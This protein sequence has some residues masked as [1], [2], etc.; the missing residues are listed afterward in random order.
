M[1]VCLGLVLGLLLDSL[2]VYVADLLLWYVLLFVA[3]V[4]VVSTVF[5]GFDLCVMFLIFRFCLGVIYGFCIGFVICVLV[6]F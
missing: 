2:V 1:F 3:G 4:W 5:F 6:C